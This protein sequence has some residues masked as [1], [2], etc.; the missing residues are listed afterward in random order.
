MNSTSI[1]FLISIKNASTG[2]NDNLIL[3][4]DYFNLALVKALYTSGLIQ[5][6]KIEAQNKVKILLRKIFNK[7]LTCNIKLVSVP[8]RKLALDYRKITEIK[9]NT[10]STM[11]FSTDKGLLTITECKKHKIGGVLLFTC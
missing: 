9:K 4:Y 3:N 7:T 6:Y 8:T 2:I 10:N 11:F 5:G 1:K